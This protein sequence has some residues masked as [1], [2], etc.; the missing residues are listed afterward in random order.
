MSRYYFI[1]S[2]A[3]DSIREWCRESPRHEHC[4]ILGG[5]DRY[6]VRAYPV[7]NVSSRPCSRF[8]FDPADERRVR[9][10]IRNDGLDVLGEWHSHP[11]GT[12]R[13]SESGRCFLQ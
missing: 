1:A 11:T 12:G 2:G 3:L 5:E 4:G 7:P 8:E 10:M 13:P 6:I 9:A